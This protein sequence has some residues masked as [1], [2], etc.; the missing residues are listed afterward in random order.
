MTPQDGQQERRRFTRISFDAKTELKQG[1]TV[2]PV[3]LVDISLHGLLVKQPEDLVADMGE[4]FNVTVHLAGDEIELHLPVHLVRISPPYLGLECNAVE[5]E[6][7][8]HL[9]RLVELNLGDPAL[10]DRELEHLLSDAK[11]AE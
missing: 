6:S 10:L 2:W 4:L 8:S 11:Q 1:D 7:I 9:R 5:L 3:E